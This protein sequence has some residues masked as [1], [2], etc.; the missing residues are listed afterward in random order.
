MRTAT[1]QFSESGGSLNGRSSSLNCLSCR[2]PYQTLHSL[3]CR[4]PFSLKIGDLKMTSTSTE[5]QKRNQNL[6]PVLVIISGTSL[7]FSGFY[8]CCAPRA[9]APVVVKKSVSQKRS[10]FHSKVLRRIPFPKI[11]SN[12]KRR[13]KGDFHIS[14]SRLETPLA[15]YRI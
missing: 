15:S 4:P 14:M 11:G 13:H 5:R 10:F 8:Q 6:A 12:K 1:F 9:S 2:N 7:A 3:N